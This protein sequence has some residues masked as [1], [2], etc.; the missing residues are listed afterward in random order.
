MKG[1]GG[2]GKSK[3]NTKGRSKK[4][5]PDLVAALEKWE[6]V[7]G[8]EIHAQLSSNTKVCHDAIARFMSIRKVVIILIDID[9]VTTECQ[10]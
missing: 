1:G 10:S 4:A 5:N 7:I 9:N 8:I 2:G 6:P 3:G